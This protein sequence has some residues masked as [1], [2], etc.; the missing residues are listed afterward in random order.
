MVVSPSHHGLMCHGTGYLMVARPESRSALP[1][2]WALHVRSPFNF[3]AAYAGP[4]FYILQWNFASG[5]D[6]VSVVRTTVDSCIRRG[7]RCLRARY[8][9]MNPRYLLSTVYVQDWLRPGSHIWVLR[10]NDICD[11]IYCKEFTPQ[12]MDN[13]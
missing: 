4:T 1:Q 7:S 9:G 3:T 5:L 12:I 8:V 6:V 13:S 2:P 11:L 10:W